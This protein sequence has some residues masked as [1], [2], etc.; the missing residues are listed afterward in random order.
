MSIHQP[1]TLNPNTFWCRAIAQTLASLGVTDIVTSPGTRSAALVSAFE[2][3][4]DCRMHVLTDERS[5]GFLALGLAKSL[6]RPTAVCVTSG[7]AVANL[8][9]ALCE[10]HA[11]ATPLVALTCDRP[12]SL[13]GAGQPQTTKQAEFC[14]P[15]VSK[16]ID[17]SDPD[18]SP[19]GL[20]RLVAELLTI[21][22]HLVDQG[23]RGP[24]QINI[25]LLGRMTSVDGAHG[26]GVSPPPAQPIAPPF[27]TAR[28]PSEIDTIAEALGLKPGLKGLI[29]VGPDEDLPVA[30]IGRLAA[31]TGYPLLLDAPGGLRGAQLPG[32]IAEADF[33]VTRR[34]V[35]ALK[36]DLLIRIGPAPVSAGL[37]Q[38]VGACRAPVLRVDRRP[39]ETDYLND[40]F[41]VLPLHDH[42]A[43]DAVGERLHHGQ[44]A[45]REHWL[46]MARACRAALPQ[47]IAAGGWSEIRVADIALGRPEF[48]FTHLANSLAIRLGNL[49][50][51][52]DGH[53]R[54]LH[55][56]RGV[57]GIDGTIATFLGEAVGEAKPG[58]L[59]IGDLAAT[60]DLSSLE[61]CLRADCRGAI[62][63]MNN[64]G[65]GLFDLLPVRGTPAYRP[66]I[67]HSAGVDFR[68]IAQAF[69]LG[70]DRCGSVEQ[71]DAALDRALRPR[72]RLR[73]IEAVITPGAIT[74]ELRDLIGR[75]TN[76]AAT[77]ARDRLASPVPTPAE[78]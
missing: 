65:G 17:L 39:V 48:G 77:E 9:P 29:V 8:V 27:P 57:A 2:E 63:V 33:L 20:E 26:W 30:A 36:P 24:V 64:D 41:R 67:R 3:R 76:P 23:A 60:H 50:T 78:A 47:A 15:L 75:L 6:R 46:D 1:L 31:R 49:L 62:V 7:S 12:R 53:E 11:N 28:A 51:G 10:A 61:A 13:R 42:A 14:A 40:A 74:T 32:A 4:S 58:L 37:Q 19:E 21:A 52:L 5:A 70:F 59:L 18:G 38:Y 72:A 71:L 55:A 16:L 22:P 44:T 25:P 73:L 68:R 54:P 69:G 45:W 35:F 56:N 34:E 43:L 66:Y